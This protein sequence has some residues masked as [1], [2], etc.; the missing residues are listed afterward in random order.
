MNCSVLESVSAAL[1]SNDAWGAARGLAL[2]MVESFN[3][4]RAYFRFV[5]NCLERVDP[6]LSRNEGLV[7]RLV[8]LEESWEVCFRYVNHPPM[9]TAVCNVVQALQTSQRLV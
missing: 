9:L 6:Q 4:L 7:E 1:R 8:D 5:N 2:D 3:A